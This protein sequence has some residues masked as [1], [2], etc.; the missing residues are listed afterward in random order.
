MVIGSRTALVEE[1][2]GDG[3]NGVLVDFF[4][5]EQMAGLTE[6]VLESPEEYCFFRQ[7]A[8]LSINDLDFLKSVNLYGRFF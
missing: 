7:E 3:E 4:C 5:V 2:I 8:R 1:V 6:E